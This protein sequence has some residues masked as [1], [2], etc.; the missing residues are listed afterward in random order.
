MT[1]LSSGRRPET[2]PYGLMRDRQWIT[3]PALNG[4]ALTAV[5]ADAWQ[6]PSLDA[7]IDRQALLR[8]CYGMATHVRAIP[9]QPQ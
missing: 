4:P 1:R 5:P 7:A 8:H 2:M 3:P 9:S 6:A